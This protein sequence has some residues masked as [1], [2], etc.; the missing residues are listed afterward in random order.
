MS[1]V[2]I[3]Y[4]K[5][6]V[7]L[8]LN[9]TKSNFFSDVTNE[10]VVRFLKGQFSNKTRFENRF[11]KPFKDVKV[12]M[13]KDVE[14]GEY[15]GYTYANPEDFECDEFMDRL[16]EIYD[17]VEPFTYEEAFKLENQE[18]QIMVFGSIN[19]SEMIGELGHE[20]VNTVG[21]PV[22]HKTF[23]HE[24]NFTGYKEYDVVY[25]V[26]KVNGEKLG[27]DDSYAIRCWC[28]TTDEE[29][30]LWIEDQYKDDPL[31]AVASTFRIHE[32][33][34]PHIKE[35]KRQGDI[36]LVE[37]EEDIEPEGE[38]VPLNAEQYFSLLTAQS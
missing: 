6:N 9:L 32:N 21:K 28:T 4:D 30:W 38:I 22:R 3:K 37:M 1:E 7:N 25:E 24:G 5:N 34:I 16:L 26:H 33:L 10:D 12:T 36:L 17:E 19:I 31:E 20:R 35:L 8:T 18:F 11:V 15:E 23:D 29:H 2:R 13:A 27:T 14:N